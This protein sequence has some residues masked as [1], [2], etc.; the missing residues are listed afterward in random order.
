MI[1]KIVRKYPFFI[2]GLTLSLIIF[3][4]YSAQHVVYEYNI[5]TFFSKN[6]VIYSQYKLFTKDFRVGSE[7]IFIFVKCDD[8]TNRD[9]LKYMLRLGNELKHLKYVENVVSP[10]SIL[11]SIYGKIPEDPIIIQ[12]TLNRYCK[13]LIPTNTLALISISISATESQQRNELAK[14]I[15]DVVKF[16]PKPA[17]VSVSVT[18]SPVVGYQ[19]M[20]SI[21]KSVRLTTTASVILMVVILFLVFS[22]VVRRK[23]FAL[24]PLLISVFS[25]I[26]V[27]GAMPILGIP[28]TEVTNGF[29]PILI[30]LAIEYAA[31][32]QSRFEEERKEGRGIDE[33]IEIA[34]KSTGLAIALAML[35]TVIGFLSM[36]F[37]G[38]PALGWFGILSALGLIVAFVLTLTFLPALLKITDK[39]VKVEVSKKEETGVL[40]RS[41]GVLAK[42]TAK[43]YRAILILT[44]VIIVFGLYGYTQIKLETNPRNYVP[45]DL[46][47]IVSLKELERLVGGQHYYVVILNFDK[48]DLN[49]VK[50]ADELG[51]YITQRESYVDNYESLAKAIV[52]FYGRMPANDIELEMV[53]NRLPSYIRDRYISGNQIAIY[54]ASHV[55]SFDEEKRL[56][57][58][59][60]K[61][62]RFFG[63]KDGFYV[64]GYTPLLMEMGRLMLFGQSKMTIAAYILIVALMFVVYRSITK[65]IVPLVS[66]TTVI[67]TVNAFMF[68]FGI[69]QTMLSTTMNSMV[70][71]LGIDFSIHVLERYLE[72]RRKFDPMMSVIRTVERTGKAIAT[73]ALTMAGGFGALLLSPFP[74]MQTF[75]VLSLVAILFSLLAS[76]T[77]VPAFLMITEK[78][79]PVRGISSV[80]GGAENV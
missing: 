54:L 75:G 33:S 78:I 36:L 57:Y 24:V 63:W 29:M 30:G 51:R 14:Q 40:E 26:F 70:L 46:P 7:N 19:I 53:L 34:I 58:S 32:L 59:I 69:K 71:G 48:L 11:V 42:V 23:I 17:G 76:L 3:S 9:V 56:Y 50:K 22:G 39:D 43:R 66:I 68:V 73:S 65:A 72:E 25:V 61:D 4:F 47:A 2:I 20:K 16:V 62:V 80:V 35:T 52:Q 67:A 10:A 45:Q 77:V 64:S 15:E 1:A 74:L 28:M 8:V 18:G 38:V 55:K 79:K 6:D 21:Q 60:Q 5:D 13:D 12:Q 31:Q 41:L 27:Y 49:V 37:S 44:V